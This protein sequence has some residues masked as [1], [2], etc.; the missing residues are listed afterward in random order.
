ML[1]RNNVRIYVGIIVYNQISIVYV[2]NT[3]YNSRC[4]VFVEMSM[5]LSVMFNKTAKE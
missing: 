3:S 1:Q 4:T 5:L 2:H